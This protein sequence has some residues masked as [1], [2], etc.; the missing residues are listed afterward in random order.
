MDIFYNSYVILPDR[1]F[2]KLR[3]LWSRDRRIVLYVT[4]FKAQ[5]LWK[6][7]SGRIQH[8]C[9]GRPDFPILCSLI[10]HRSAFSNYII[11]G[12]EWLQGPKIVSYLVGHILA[13][14]YIAMKVTYSWTAKRMAQ[15]Q[16]WADSI[17]AMKHYWALQLRIYSGA[18]T[19][20][21]GD[22]ELQRERGR[23]KRY[24]FCVI[25]SKMKPSD[26]FRAQPK[27]IFH[28]FSF[29]TMQVGYWNPI[30]IFPFLELQSPPIDRFYAVWKRWLAYFE[31]LIV[32][33][34]LGAKPET[35]IV[36]PM[37]FFLH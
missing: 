32:G 24:R 3:T 7:R 26:F 16:I 23:K 14:A 19:P 6:G 35:S 9:P 15:K 18:V 21:N 31:A 30:D 34:E 4:D 2:Y 10:V 33:R 1:P 5:K 25:Q 29:V 11:F 28:P 36:C 17:W 13:C 37:L 22:I 12:D 20:I 8:L 27:I